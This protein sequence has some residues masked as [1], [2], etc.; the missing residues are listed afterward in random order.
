M[1][2]LGIILLWL[3][4]GL[5]AIWIWCTE[6]DELHLSAAILALLAGPIAAMIWGA[7]KLL[8]VDGPVIWRRKR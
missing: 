8:D 5:L 1:I 6:F 2:A 4:F 3:F 7:L